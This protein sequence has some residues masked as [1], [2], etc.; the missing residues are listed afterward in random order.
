MALTNYNL[1]RNHCRGNQNG[2]TFVCSCISRKKTKRMES[3][4][5]PDPSEETN[6]F[7]GS[8][9]SE[10]YL[11]SLRGKRQQ[12]RKVKRTNLHACR[13]RLKFKWLDELKAFKMREE[14]NLEHNHEPENSC[15][16][17]VS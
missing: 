13:F 4:K 12:K 11:G 9:G 5:D 7:D 1:K 14:S 8:D 17:K 10:S 15:T 16:T 6:E 3:E 2:I